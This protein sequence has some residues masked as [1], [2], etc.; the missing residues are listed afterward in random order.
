MYSFNKTSHDANWR[1]FRQPLFR[2]GQRNLLPLI[3]RK[4]QPKSV[5]SAP[6][7]TEGSP[8]ESVER[9]SN[10]LRTSIP[11]QKRKSDYRS[12][13]FDILF[14]SDEMGNEQRGE[15]EGEQ[16]KDVVL[17]LQSRVRQLEATVM[18]MQGVIEKLISNTYAGFEGKSGLVY[19][20]VYLLVAL[21]LIWDDAGYTRGPSAN[22]AT[23]EEGGMR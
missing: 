1:E 20:C 22:T 4:M 5:D 9:T 8:C 17:D 23:D 21:S 18:Q 13:N 11:Q 6:V 15:G 2:R 7:K 19:V 12:T 16:R 14:Y 10:Q 3:S